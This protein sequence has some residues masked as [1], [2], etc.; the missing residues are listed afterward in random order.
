MVGSRTNDI[1]CHSVLSALTQADMANFVI[2]KTRV[3]K[4]LD[5]LDITSAGSL[6][7]E[8]RLSVGQVA[9]RV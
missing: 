7:D 9:L 8:W 3:I 2:A 6:N 5:R 4:V 1:T